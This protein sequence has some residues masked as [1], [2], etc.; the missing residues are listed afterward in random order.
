MCLFHF[1]TFTSVQLVILLI[2]ACISSCLLD[3]LI[4][5]HVYFGEYKSIISNKYLIG[6]NVILLNNLP[7]FFCGFIGTSHNEADSN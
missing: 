5:L 4:H 6:S 3:L 1:L 7:L 2:M